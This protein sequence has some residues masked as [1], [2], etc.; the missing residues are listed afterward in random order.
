MLKA[1]NYTSQFKRDL[2]KAKKQNRNLEV[3]QKVIELLASNSPLPVKFR[4]HKLVGNYKNR[5]ECHLGPD[6][7]LI[8]LIKYNEL[9][10]ERLGTHSDLFK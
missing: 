1:I 9:Y 2:E 3:L 6:F 8:Y 10:L 4:D 5:R 7:L